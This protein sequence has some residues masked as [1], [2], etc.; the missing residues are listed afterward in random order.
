MKPSLVY[1]PQP[2]LGMF[3]LQL[4]YIV[5]T[6]YQYIVLVHQDFP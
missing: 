5:V 6:T 4:K 1:V 2:S 3:L